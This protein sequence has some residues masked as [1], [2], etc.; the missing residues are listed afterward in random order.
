MI[1]VLCL[2]C[3]LIT[4]FGVPFGVSINDNHWETKTRF[5][6]TGCHPWPLIS[7]LIRGDRDGVFGI[8]WEGDPPASSSNIVAIK[9]SYV[10]WNRNVTQKGLTKC[11]GEM[12]VK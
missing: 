10:A 1:R 8:T 6:I 12:G 4:R 5:L 11:M 7:A 3:T 9:Y 2:K